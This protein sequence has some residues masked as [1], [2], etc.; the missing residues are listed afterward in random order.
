MKTDLFIIF[1]SQSQKDRFSCFFFTTIQLLASYL[2]RC[3][4][5]MLDANEVSLHLLTTSGGAFEVSQIKCVFKSSFQRNFCLSDH[6]LMVLTA[7]GMTRGMKYT[8]VARGTL[9]QQPEKVN[10]FTALITIMLL[11]HYCC[12]CESLRNLP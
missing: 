6:L 8:V 7:S 9:Q 10:T 3:I 2:L 12:F 4:S 5:E 1:K 11:Y